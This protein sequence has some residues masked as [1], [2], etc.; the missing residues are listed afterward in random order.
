MNHIFALIFLIAVPLLLTALSIPL[1]KRMAW[2]FNLVDYP[3]Q[4][5]HKSHQRPVPYGGGLAIFLGTLLPMVLV[6]LYTLYLLTLSGADSFPSWA[7]ATTTL[8][9]G[10][11]H[12]SILLGCASILCLTGLIDDWRGLPPLPRFLIEIATATILV[13]EAPEFRLGFFASNAFVAV[14]LTIFWIVSMTNAFNF[15]DNMDGLTAGISAISLTLLGLMALISGHIAGAALSLVMVG[16]LLGFLL[17]NFPPASV[18]MGDAGGLF[19]GFMAGSL[20][21]LLSHHFSQPGALFPYRLAPLLVLTIP[22]YD[23]VSVVLIRLGNGVPPWVGDNNHISHRLVHMELSRR[24]AVLIIYLLTLLTGLPALF[25]L[26]THSWTAWLLLFL[27]PVFLGIVA[28][29]DLTARRR[30]GPS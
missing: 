4:G 26:R 11:N 29:I 16:A 8:F 5:D 1:I 20:S 28:L 17:Y 7:L 12:I 14:P 9:E 25:L 3:A 21:A 22:L 6:L 30:H 23:L 19:L 10:I 2:S 13:F 24:H 15:L 27:V 18:F